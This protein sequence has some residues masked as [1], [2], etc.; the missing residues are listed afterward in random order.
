MDDGDNEGR[1]GILCFYLLQY[2]ADALSAAVAQS[3]S[4]I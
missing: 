4:V 3:H 2:I 1:D